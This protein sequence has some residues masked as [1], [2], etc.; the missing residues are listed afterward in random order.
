MSI[1]LV[2]AFLLIARVCAQQASCEDCPMRELC[3]KQFQSW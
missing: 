1:D 3:G 2:K